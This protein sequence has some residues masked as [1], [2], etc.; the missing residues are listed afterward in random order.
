MATEATK[1]ILDTRVAIKGK[2]APIIRELLDKR[3]EK[4]CS[5]KYGNAIEAILM[6]YIEIKGIKFLGQGS[7]KKRA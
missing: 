7:K 6:E 3:M 5:K 4:D 2:N 1:D